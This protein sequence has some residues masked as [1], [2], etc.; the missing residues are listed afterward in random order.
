MC[1][2]NG[3]TLLNQHDITVYAA[4]LYESRNEVTIL[5]RAVVSSESVHAGDHQGTSGYSITDKGNRPP[6]LPVPLA[7]MQRYHANLLAA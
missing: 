2:L 5:N 1:L 6:R 4:R 7:F 3:I